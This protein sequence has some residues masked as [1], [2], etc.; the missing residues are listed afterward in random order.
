MRAYDSSKKCETNDFEEFSGKVPNYFLFR[1]FQKEGQEDQ[2]SEGR[3]RR[4]QCSAE[5]GGFPRR[6]ALQEVETNDFGRVVVVQ[7]N[8][9]PMIFSELSRRKARR[10]R[11]AREGTEGSNVMQSVGTA[12]EELLCKRCVCVRSFGKVRNQH[13][14]R[15]FPENAK[16]IN[17]SELSRRRARKT[18]ETR[19]GTEGSNVVQSLGAASEEM[20]CKRCL[21]DFGSRLFLAQALFYSSPPWD[22]NANHKI[23]RSKLE[24]YT[25]R[26]KDASTLGIWKHQHKID[27]S[28]GKE[29]RGKNTKA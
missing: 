18:S 21:G 20:L 29:S 12:P 7:K 10:T 28:K 27:L 26:K 9:K 2:G 1:V 19:G 15:S 24:K 22:V 6:N 16:N 17:F 14:L 3:D 8:A 25:K 11:E 23:N 13:F 5:F 4:K